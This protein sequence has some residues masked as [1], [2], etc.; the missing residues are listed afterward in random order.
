MIVVNSLAFDPQPFPEGWYAVEIKACENCNGILTR[1]ACKCDHLK[2][3]C[4]CQKYCAQCIGNMLMPPLEAVV[5]DQRQVQEDSLPRGDFRKRQHIHYD[6]SLLSKDQRYAAKVYKP[7][8]Y[9]KYGDWKKRLLDKFAIQGALTAEDIQEVIGC[10]GSPSDA[11]RH[12][13]FAI[14]NCK[15]PR[16]TLINYCRPITGLRGKPFGIFVLEARIVNG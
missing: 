16:L 13:Q 14:R 12:V 8:R 15:F 4:G 6:D 9:H 3:R 7:R 11:M 2:A 1:K 5:E 10:N